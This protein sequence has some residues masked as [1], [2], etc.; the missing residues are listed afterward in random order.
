MLEIY[1]WAER[2]WKSKQPPTEAVSSCL[3]QNKH[4]YT[5]RRLRGAEPPLPVGGTRACRE[6]SCGF[7][8]AASRDSPPSLPSHPL[9]TPA[10]LED[11]RQ[12]PHGFSEAS[13]SD[14][15]AGSLSRETVHP[16][17]AD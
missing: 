2:K 10:A 9:C 4:V 15:E 14:R 16:E 3:K 5:Q 7:P 17:L 11:P 13:G 6:E 1:H 8:R 12:Q